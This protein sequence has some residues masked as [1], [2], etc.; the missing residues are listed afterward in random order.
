MFCIYV[1]CLYSFFP[2]DPPDFPIIQVDGCKAYEDCVIQ[3]KE[4]NILKCSVQ[5][6]RLNV[7]LTVTDPSQI[8]TYTKQKVNETNG[9]YSTSLTFEFDLSGDKRCQTDVYLFCN[10]SGVLPEFAS[11]RQIAIR[12][13]MAFSFIIYVCLKKST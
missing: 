10:T 8:L 6:V 12:S 1:I 5:N 4:T 11:V 3:T 2:I 13:G 7:N 9:I